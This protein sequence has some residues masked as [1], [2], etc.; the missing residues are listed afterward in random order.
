MTLVSDCTINYVDSDEI[1]STP[2]LFVTD[3]EDC[4]G[5]RHALQGLM[6]IYFL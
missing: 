2:C 1:S 6:I 4:T 5:R 3:G